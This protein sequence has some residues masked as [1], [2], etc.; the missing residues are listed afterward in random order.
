MEALAPEGGGGGVERRAEGTHCKRTCH[1][2]ISKKKSV[3]Q[4]I[5]KPKEKKKLVCFECPRHVL[6]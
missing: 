4:G 2:T 3:Q 1:R 5:I 6:R